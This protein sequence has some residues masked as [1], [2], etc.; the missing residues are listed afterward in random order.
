MS[1]LLSEYYFKRVL[2]PFRIFLKLTLSRSNT[3]SI[4]AFYSKA[5]CTF[6]KECPTVFKECITLCDGTLQKSNAILQLVLNILL[7]SMNTAQTKRA[8]LLSKSVLLAFSKEY[9]TVSQ[10][11]TASIK[12]CQSLLHVLK[13]TTRIK[14]ALSPFNDFIS[15]QNWLFKY[16]CMYAFERNV[17][18][19]QECP[20]IFCNMSET[21]SKEYC[22]ILHP[23]KVQ[24]PAAQHSVT[25]QCD[26][27]SKKYPTIPP[28]V[29]QSV[30]LQV[31]TY[32]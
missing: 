6:L 19:S 17:Q 13:N 16:Y 11:T 30:S 5:C 21:L 9:S 25:K 2:H 23:M 14:R 3:A 24:S 18:S 26:M 15:R 4:E 28:K 8:F 27:F 32:F 20:T 12:V 1:R 31:L 29:S 10:S 7:F 22:I